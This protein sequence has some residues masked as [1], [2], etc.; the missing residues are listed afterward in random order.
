MEQVILQTTYQ[1]FTTHG[2]HQFTMDELANRLGIS[3]KTL[4][5]FFPSRQDLVEQVSNLLS[6]NYLADLQAVDDQKMDSLQRLLGYI[7]AVVEFCKKTSPVFFSDLRKHYPFQWMELQMKLDQALHARVKRVLET[8]ISEGLIRGNLH[9]NLVISIWQQHIQTD[10]EYASKLV[11]DYSKDEVF[12]Q[13]MYLF[14]YGIIAPGAIPRLE[15]EL[16]SLRP[17]TPA[18]SQ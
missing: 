7:G 14:L 4:Y 6:E 15:S 2:I 17:G 18:V 11:N 16:L 1:L 12:R 9:P 5:R 3:K 13:A 10:F 8:G